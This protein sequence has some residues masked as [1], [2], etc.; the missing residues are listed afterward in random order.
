MSNL[1]KDTFDIDGESLYEVLQQGEDYFVKKNGK[2]LPHP[3]TPLYD[4]AFIKDTGQSTLISFNKVKT[5]SNGSVVEN[6]FDL[7]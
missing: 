1:Y 5:T 7:R 4:L 6:D 3:S 2:S